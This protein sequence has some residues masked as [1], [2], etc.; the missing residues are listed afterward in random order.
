MEVPSGVE[1]SLRVV[2]I[3]APPVPLLSEPEQEDVDANSSREPSKAET[4]LTEVERRMDS[5]HKLSEGDE[6]RATNVAQDVSA[7]DEASVAAPCPSLTSP[8]A[9]TETCQ[10]AAT[11]E[12][13]PRVALAEG[14]ERAEEVSERS[15][16]PKPTSQLSEHGVGVADAQELA[17]AE[18]ADHDRGMS[19]DSVC[20]FSLPSRPAGVPVPERDVPNDVERGSTEVLSFSASEAPRARIPGHLGPM[21]SFATH[22][23]AASPVDLSRSM[24]RP[25]AHLGPVPSAKQPL[26]PPRA[27]SPVEDH[28]QLLARYPERIPVICKRAP[29]SGL[30]PLSRSKFLVPGHM[31]C[32]EFKYIVHRHLVEAAGRG[33]VADQTI[34]LFVGTTSPK[35]GASMAEL[36]ERHRSPDGLLHVAYAAEN[37]LG[38]CV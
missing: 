17:A 30:P 33:L 7:S 1:G 32:S 11:K 34:F 5:D 21:T 28:S 16:S 22:Q 29:R 3:V 2:D 26:P 18:G 8:P 25:P 36:F 9:L 6:Q 23:R 38:G 14:N 13:S 19:A 37:T 15:V 10:Q 12:D 20:A 31:P 27:E 24:R 4:Q 35:G